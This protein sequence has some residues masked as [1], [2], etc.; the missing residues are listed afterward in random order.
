MAGDEGA[1]M[2]GTRTI[3]RKRTTKY[4]GK[5]F[6]RGSSSTNGACADA[7]EPG[8]KRKRENERK[9]RGQ[10][11]EGTQRRRQR[12]GKKWS[13]CKTTRRT[14]NGHGNTHEEGRGSGTER[15]GGR[16]R[17]PKGVQTTRDL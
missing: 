4:E 14:Q 13:A 11:N 3:D 7:D 2:G 1:Q 5:E 12:F 15:N 10:Q 6:E 9:R 17:E 16:G 8:R